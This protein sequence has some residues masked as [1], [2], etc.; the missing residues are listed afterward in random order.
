M[1]STLKA[2]I[3]GLD[4]DIIDVTMT[5]NGVDTVIP[6]VMSPVDL[7][8]DATP[9]VI[10]NEDGAAWWAYVIIVL[11]E[12]LALLLLSLLLCNICK[13][14]GLIMLIPVAVVVVLDIFFIQSWALSLT[15]LLEPYLGWLPFS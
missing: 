2:D 9:P 3:T 7:A 4:F 15:R 14:H 1:I 10:T 6:V 8:A 5:K 13:L 12:I 11:A